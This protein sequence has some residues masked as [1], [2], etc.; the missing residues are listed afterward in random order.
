MGKKLLS[1]ID[2][3]ILWIVAILVSVC[4]IIALSGC[5]GCNKPAYI[6]PS[7]VQVIEQT[8]NPAIDSLKQVNSLLADSVAKLNTE[9]AKQ[10]SK[11]A[12]A[13]S[14]AS[15]TGKRLQEALNNQ[16]TGSIIVYADDIIE[17]FNS[18][19]QETNRQDSIQENIIEKQAATI[20]NN[21]AETELQ[22]SKFNLLKRAY[23]IQEVQLSD[24]ARANE[25]LQKKLKRSKFF[26][27]VLGIGTA[28]GAVLA[29]IMFL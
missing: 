27:K 29:G 21:R 15:A 3:Y 2:K 1:F 20:I 12:I 16:D 19:I 24:A 28:A 25:K 11:T 18:Y 9:L 7:Q 22:E 23:N 5:K 4:A 8:H 10:K 6:P 14:K 13:E 17:E 26:N